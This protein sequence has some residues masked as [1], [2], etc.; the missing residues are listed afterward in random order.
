[1]IIIYMSFAS[2]SYAISIDD[3]RLNVG[4]TAVNRLTCDLIN[5]IYSIIYSKAH[6]KNV[7][8]SA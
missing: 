1:M 8:S 2:L 7:Y 6:Q 5:T 3:W 4:A